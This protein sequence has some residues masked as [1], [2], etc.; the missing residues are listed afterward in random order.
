MNFNIVYMALI[1]LS[2][3]SLAIAQSPGELDKSFGNGGKVNVGIMGYMDVAKS[4][5][6]QKDGKIV[7]VGYGQ[8]SPAKQ[9][10]LSMARYMP[11]GELDYDFGHLGIVVSKLSDIEG[12]AH[13]VAIQQDDKIVVT[14]YSISSATN[15]EEITV[16]RFNPNGSIDETF[17]DNG[18]VI[19]E[20][21]NEKDIGESVVIQPDGKIVVVGTTYHTP[22]LDIVLVR[23]NEDG[24]TDYGFGS[25]GIVITDINS[26]LDIGKSVVVQP[27]SK[28]VVG[29][30][31]HVGEKF[32]MT[33]LRYNSNGDLDPSFGQ[34][35]IVI[36]DINGR[37]GEMDLAIQRDGKI[38]LVAPS[39]ING[40]HHFT[41]VRFNPNGS[42]DKNFGKNGIT[43]TIIGNHSEAES[44]A[45]DSKGNIIVA[46]TVELENE[47]FAV[48]MYNNDGNLISDF[49]DNGIVI[50]DFNNNSIDRAHDVAIDKTGNIIVAGETKS[51][52]TTFGLV[53]LFGR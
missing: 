49:G 25:A 11:N 1:Y 34:N 19:T 41:V 26:G 43:K 9:K 48:A 3:N 35:G 53:K 47:N 39:E 2:F 22:S 32:Y 5:A 10:G 44:V 4:S 52:Y 17:G 27:D 18:I 38:V 15:N 30:Y 20:L 6:L 45:L 24:T 36:T 51:N 40:S 29:G 31:T 16:V 21:S 42:L 14:G 12:E 13:S 50:I 37:R 8:E 28:I 46:G 23:Y 7:V 33:L